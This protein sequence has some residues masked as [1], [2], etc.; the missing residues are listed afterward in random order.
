MKILAYDIVYDID[1]E[2]GVVE[3]LPTSFEFD[4]V[5]D[6]DEIADMAFAVFLASA[7]LDA[8][9]AFR[10]NSKRV[11]SPFLYSGPGILPILARNEA[12]RGLS[13]LLTGAFRF[14]PSAF[15]LARPFA[16]RPPL[17]FFPSLRCHAGVF[18]GHFLQNHI[19]GVNCSRQSQYFI[20]W[21][22]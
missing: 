2:D 20:L 19:H 18:I 17:G 13:P 8:P 11:G 4:N 14:M 3:Q 16:F 15:A 9:H 5:E 10:L 7:L 12:L 1:E 22:F 6:T 21:Q